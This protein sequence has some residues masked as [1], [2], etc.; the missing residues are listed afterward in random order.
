LICVNPEITYAC[1][2]TAAFARK[3]LPNAPTQNAAR[4]TPF[5]N[6]AATELEMTMSNDNKTMTDMQEMTKSALAM[7]TALPGAGSQSTHFWQAQDMILEEVEKFSSAWF[8]R[9]HEGTRAAIETSRQ[10]AEGA[11]S[12]PAA[13]MEILTNWQSRSIE[14]LT[15]DAKD[16]S[17]MMSRCTEAFVKNE[18]E[19]VAETAE[20]AKKATK[21]AKSEPV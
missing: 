10:L 20:I 12:D 1:Y 7:F 19:A 16:C 18:V 2:Y 6:L 21:S 17:E 4:E 11:M 9:R 8:K 3:G 13:A 14:R 5:R 15:E